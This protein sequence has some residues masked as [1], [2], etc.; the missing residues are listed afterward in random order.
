[1]ENKENPLAV[2]ADEILL[3]M[4]ADEAIDFGKAFFKRW[5]KLN[6]KKWS[7]FKSELKN[8]LKDIMNEK[9]K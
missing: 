9:I 7:D 6:P 8:E 3:E 5:K 1:M 2:I 4:S